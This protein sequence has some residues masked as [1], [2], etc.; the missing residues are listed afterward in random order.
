MNFFDLGY[1]RAMQRKKVFACAAVA[2][3]LLSGEEA[4]LREAVES[5]RLALGN[6]WSATVAI[7]FLSGAKCNDVIQSLSGEDAVHKSRLYEVHLVAK[8]ICATQNLGTVQSPDGIDF[9]ELRRLLLAS[10]DRPH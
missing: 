7:Q 1:Q 5:L 3:S 10:K 2:E 4:S 9:A 6:G 8:E